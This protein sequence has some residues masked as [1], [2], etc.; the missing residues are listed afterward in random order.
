MSTV[1][2]T[3][4]LQRLTLTSSLQW[5]SLSGSNRHAIHTS[6]CLH[7]HRTSGRFKVT[8][9]FSNPLTYEQANKP[10]YIGVRKSWNSWNTSNVLEGLRKSETLVEDLF[11]RKFMFGTWHR[12]F[13]SEVLIK[14]RANLI[15]I[16][17]VVLQSIPAQKLYFL[18]GY[19]EEMLSLV[20]KCPIK[21]EIQT[22]RKPDALVIKH[23]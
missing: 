15:V 3:R 6:V 12:L 17:G 8:R 1:T 19:T 20:L 5:A 11:I 13:L 22:S 4:S 10:E 21:I 23:V 18:I 16:G 7:K 14:R 2:G 9:D